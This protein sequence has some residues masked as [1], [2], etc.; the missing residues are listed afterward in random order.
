MVL[1]DVVERA[2]VGMIELRNHARLAVEALAKLS[3]CGE[4]G[5]ERLDR[6]DAVESRVAGFVDLAHAARA[7]GCDD[8]IRPEA[9]TRV[10]RHERSWR[11]LPR[12]PS[13]PTT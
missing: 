5:R 7:R 1:A 3:I 2:D 6:D 12:I 11:I 4:L 8:F 9:S 10:E 13:H